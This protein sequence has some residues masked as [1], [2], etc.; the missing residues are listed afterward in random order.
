[1]IDYLQKTDFKA[2]ANGSHQVDGERVL[3]NVMTYETKRPEEGKF[4]AH[5][6]YIDIQV[7]LE[8]EERCCCTPLSLT[9]ELGPYDTG[10]DI[11]FLVGPRQ[12]TMQLNPDNFAV[13]FP[14]DAHMPSL[15]L[16]KARTVRKVVMKV[17]A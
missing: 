6:K 2:L 15:S 8:G 9:T 3:A 7:V 10:K 11:G 1:A 16:D 14:Q 12:T 4:E 17:A 13:F 5:R